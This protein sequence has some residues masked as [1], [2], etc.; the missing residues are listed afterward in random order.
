L[1]TLSL[2]CSVYEKAPEAFKLLAKQ[3]IEKCS[4]NVYKRHEQS[5]KTGKSKGKSLMDP[6]YRP[7][8]VVIM[9]KDEIDSQNTQNQ[10]LRRSGP[11]R[12]MN[13]DV[14]LQKVETHAAGTELIAQVTLLKALEPINPTGAIA[15][16]PSEE[17]PRRALDSISPN[18]VDS[19]SPIEM[20]SSKN[21]AYEAI[22]IIQILETYPSDNL[23]GTYQ[24]MLQHASRSGN[25]S[26]ADSEVISDLSTWAQIMDTLE[27][28]TLRDSA[29]SMLACLEFYDW[30][31]E[32]VSY[33][34]AQKPNREGI[35]GKRI[36]EIHVLDRLV[37][38]TRKTGDEM[39]DKMMN[40]KR[41]ALTN[42]IHKGEAVKDLVQQFGLGIVFSSYIW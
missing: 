35:L 40:R 16:L 39:R 3:A 4:L 41:S 13:T 25:T 11:S 17:I 15:T 32:K 10:P 22:R 20:I 9:T 37:G 19:F 24:R 18:K 27:A 36:A 14:P 33:Q 23:S 38:Y 30:F 7:A 2:L 8:T 42:W 5:E 31:S 29:F 26:S 12:K 21:N 28:R 6:S 34:L 1:Q